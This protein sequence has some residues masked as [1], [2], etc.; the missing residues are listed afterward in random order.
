MPGLPQ[1]GNDS[2]GKERPLRDLPD[3]GADLWGSMFEAGV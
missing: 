2:V 1:T 3:A